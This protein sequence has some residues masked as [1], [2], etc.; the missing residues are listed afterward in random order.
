MGAEAAATNRSHRRLEAKGAFPS[1]IQK[2]SGTTYTPAHRRDS[3][4]IEIVCRGKK[5]G[6]PAPG[7]TDLDKV[8]IVARLSCGELVRDAEQ[9]QVLET[10]LH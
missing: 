7:A 9:P 10:V 2:I 1:W 3:A 8:L 6:R 4:K 5:I